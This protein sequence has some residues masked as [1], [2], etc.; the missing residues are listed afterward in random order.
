MKALLLFL[1][2]ISPLIAQSQDGRP[3][4]SYGS[5]GVVV[6]EIGRAGD[7]WIIDADRTAADK[8]FVAGSNYDQGFYNFIV[9]Y[10]EDGSIDTSFGTNGILWTDGSDEIYEGIKVLADGKILLQSTLDDQYTLTRLLPSG[11]LDLSFGIDGRIRPFAPTVY[12]GKMLLDPENNFLL[13][14]ID[15]TPA[16]PNVIVKKLKPDG[17]LDPDFG[18]NGSVA[19]FLGNFDEFYPTSF[20]LT[21]EGIFIGL[22]YRENNSRWNKIFKLMPDGSIASTF[23]NNGVATIPIDEEYVAFF[24][25]FQNGSFLVSGSY[26]DSFNQEWNRKMIK[27]FPDATLDES[28][29]NNGSLTGFYD[30]EIQENQR[31]ILN[32]SFQDFEG[33]ITLSYSRFFPDGNPD[34]SFQFIS[35]YIEL[36]SAHFLPLS[37]GKFLVVGSDIWYNGP[38]INIILQ[39]FNNTTLSIYDFEEKITSV[40]P[41]PSS[42]IFTVETEAFSEKIPYQISDVTGKTI[43]S[44]RLTSRQQQ[45]DISSAQSGLYFLKTSRGVFRLLKKN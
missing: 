43:A 8:I 30:G 26:F 3:D 7:K 41:N 28:F 42:G 21:S 24:T 15:V 23:G 5:N 37:T 10:F 13:L 32:A 35:N 38:S 4:V 36:G 44:G 27:L 6:S 19:Y 9:S 17:S 40:Y 14:G 12:M 33:G 25:I 31:M 18:T 2:S 34:Q 11:E 20:R 22:N 16:Q 29:G 45:I 39:R 1:F